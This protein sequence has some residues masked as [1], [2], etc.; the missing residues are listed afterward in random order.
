LPLLVI[1]DFELL[2]R[3]DEVFSNQAKDFAGECI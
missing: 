2:L 1:L 3:M